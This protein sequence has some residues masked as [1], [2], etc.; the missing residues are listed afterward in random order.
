MDPVTGWKNRVLCG[1]EDVQVI[2]WREG[3]G[4]QALEAGQAAFSNYPS[5]PTDDRHSTERGR[6]R[7]A[8]FM[9][10]LDGD[11]FEGRFR[12]RLTTKPKSSPASA[13]GAQQDNHGSKCPTRLLASRITRTVRLAVS[14][15]LRLANDTPTPRPSVLSGPRCHGCMVQARV[16]RRSILRWRLR[17]VSQRVHE[18][19]LR[20][21]S[22]LLATAA[23]QWQ[24]R[25]PPYWNSHQRP[26]WPA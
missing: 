13:S 10:L 20:S 9:A 24:R 7:F 23:R 6:G 2:L 4:N 16:R 19:R 26:R 22:S 21:N 12:D 25:Y 1:A 17:R 8:A 11:R 14:A 5:F 15:S 18:D 3:K